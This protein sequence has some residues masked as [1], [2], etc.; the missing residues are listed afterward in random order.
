MAKGP[1]HSTHYGAGVSPWGGVFGFV[2]VVAVSV[3]VVGGPE[4]NQHL[5]RRVVLFA[6]W[7]PAYPTL[8]GTRLSA[9]LDLGSG[10]SYPRPVG[11]NSAAIPPNPEQSA[12]GEDGVKVERRRAS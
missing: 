12:K 6:V 4:R 9:T 10:T 5:R 1:R 2:I 11:R 8:R 7:I 3:T